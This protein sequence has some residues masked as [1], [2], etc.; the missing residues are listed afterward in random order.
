MNPKKSFTLGEL[1]AYTDSKLIG[2]AKHIISNVADLD[3]ATASDASFLAQ[4][5]HDQA[6]RYEKAMLSSKAGVVFIS[7]NVTPLPG[8]NFLVAQN[9]SEAFQKTLEGLF[10]HYLTEV[11]GFT[12]I[13]PS[14]VIHPTAKLGQRVTVGPHAVIDRDVTVGDDTTIDPHCYVGYEATIGSQTHLHSQVTVRERCHIGNRVIL[15]P[16]AVIGACGFGFLTDAKGKHSKL[17]Q[18]GNVVIEDDVEI[19]ANTTIDRSR[20]QSTIIARGT[21]IDNLVQIGHG[22]QTGIAGSTHTGANVVIAGQ[23]AVA[24]HITIADRTMIAGKSGVSKSID[25][26]GKYGGI[27]VMP[28][29]EYNRNAVYLRNIHKYIKKIQELEKRL[30]N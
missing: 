9:P 30:N 12:G 1:A 6:V 19:G 18:V 22:G 17:N 14:A 7:P 15:Q 26:P 2:D 29:E 4:S 20:F 28:I 16:G 3:S 25:K 24:G 8:R 5:Q 27:P 21:K 23:V 10:G 13:H 11:S